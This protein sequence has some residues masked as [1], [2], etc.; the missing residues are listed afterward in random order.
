[1]AQ[2]YF[3]LELIHDYLALGVDEQP[4]DEQLKNKGKESDNW[5]DRNLSDL[6]T[7][8]LTPTTYPDIVE[9]SS[10]Y[11][12][13]LWQLRNAADPTKIPAYITLAKQ[14]LHE[15]RQKLMEA[16]DNTKK[17]K[18]LGKSVGNVTKV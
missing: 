4:F 12:A 2:P 6:L 8:P 11:A 10:M 17:G 16:G 18:M 1:M 15:F 7:V 13:G 14:T 5:I 3:K 9:I